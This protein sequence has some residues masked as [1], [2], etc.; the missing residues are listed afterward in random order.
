M[1]SAPILYVG[2]KQCG[3]CSRYV[4][5]SHLV[6]NKSRTAS[7]TSSPHIPK[8]SFIEVWREPTR[9]RSFDPVK[10]ETAFL[11][12]SELPGLVNAISSAAATAGHIIKHEPRSLVKL[13]K[14]ELGALIRQHLTSNQWTR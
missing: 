11:T 9:T 1:S 2:P 3:P 6:L 4:R 8:I 14:V 13:K 10:E 7:V 5:T 12:P